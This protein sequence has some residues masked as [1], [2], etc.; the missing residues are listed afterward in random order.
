[1]ILIKTQ[2]Q[3]VYYYESAKKKYKG[4]PDR[5]F[6]IKY[7]YKNKQIQEKVGWLSDGYS[8]LYASQRR[9]ERLLGSVRKVDVLTVEKASELYVI[10]AKENKSS[11]IDDKR[12]LGLFVKMYGSLHIDEITPRDIEI[13]ITKVRARTHT[14]KGGGT[15]APA[16][17]RQYKQVVHRMFNYLAENELYNQ[18]N[19]ASLVTVSVPD[20]TV[21]EALTDEE[22]A[23]LVQACTQNEY[24]DNGGELILL[25]LYTGLR[26]SSLF[27]LK[28]SDVNLA[29]NTLTLGETKN[30]RKDYVLLSKKALRVLEKVGEK[31]DCEYVFPSRMG[32]QRKDIRTLW[33]RVKKDAG[34]REH[35]RFHDIRHTFATKMLEAGESLTV[36]SR[37]LHHSSVTVTQKY[38]HIRD[39]QLQAA[40]ARVDSMFSET[41]N[42]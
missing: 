30:R 10:N 6:Y 16:T 28:W 38:A 41:E 5:C 33:A 8:A 26:L 22:C 40:A 20:N 11:W 36:I 24:R 42:T 23:A 32:G 25:A 31:G 34:I 13:F 12:R 19:P 4:K 21:V 39:R 35:V 2:K 14:R 15:V 18:R 27:R 1:M 17:V 7:Y 37:L 3:G 29:K 9:S